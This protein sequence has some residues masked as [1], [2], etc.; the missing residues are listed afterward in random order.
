MLEII[1]QQYPF[2]PLVWKPT[3]ISFAEGL[4]LLRGDGYEASHF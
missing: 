2:E 3:R 4:A 1:G